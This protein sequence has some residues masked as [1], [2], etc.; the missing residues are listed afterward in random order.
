MPKKF[1]A[2][3]NFNPAR[4]PPKVMKVA[5]D[6]RRCRRRLEQRAVGD[7]GDLEVRDFRPVGRVAA[8]H[9]AGRRLHVFVGRRVGHRG[10]SATALTVM[11]AVAVPPP[12]PPSVPLMDACTWKRPAEEVRRRREFQSGIALDRGNERVARDD[13]HAVVRVERPMRDVRNL[14]IRHLEPSAGLRLMINPEVDCAS[15]LVDEFVTD[16]VSA[17]G[18]TVI[19]AVARRRRAHYRRSERGLHL[20]RAGPEEVG[21]RG[22]LQTRVALGKCDEL[23]IADWADAVVL[24]ER[25]VRDPGDLEMRHFA[26]SAALRLITSPL[27]VW[28]SSFVVALV[29]DGVSATG[30]TEIVAVITPPPSPASPLLID[31]WTWN[32]AVPKKFAAGVNFRPAFPWAKVMNWPFVTGVVPSFRNSVPLV[33]PVILKWVTSLPSAALRLITNP[34]VVCVSSLAVALVIEGIR[35]PR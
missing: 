6:D 33:M 4:R 24:E 30:L 3:V 22:E 21:G 18:L 20:E 7:A 31:A 2:G 11:V 8:D 15:S 1:A 23:T 35:R 26:P 19:V 34:L 29:T 16:G 10:V 14:E 9:Q 32:D 13:R 5:V 28:V 12:S 25:S 27:V 17:T